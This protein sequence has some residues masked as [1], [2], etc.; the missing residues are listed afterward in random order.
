MVIKF[1][2]PSPSYELKAFKFSVNWADTT[3]VPEQGYRG[4]WSPR[5]GQAGVPAAIFQCQGQ[6]HFTSGF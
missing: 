5:G 6:V 3:G 1:T 2:Q 4:L